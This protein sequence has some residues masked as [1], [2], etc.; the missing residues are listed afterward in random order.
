MNRLWSSIP[1]VALAVACS[2]SMAQHSHSDGHGHSHTQP[3]QAGTTGK[4]SESSPRIHNPNTPPSPEELQANMAKSVILFRESTADAG[5]ILD[6]ES[7]PLSFEFKNTGSEPLEIRYVKPSC[8]CTATEMD[9]TVFAPGETGTIKVEFDPKGKQGAVRRAIT[10]YT[11]S[12]S[13]P[14]HTIYVAAEVQQ[15][16][17]REPSVVA[18]SMLEKGQVATETMKIYGR[19]D[20]FKVTRATSK[21]PDV[22]EIEVSDPVDAEYRGETLRMSEVTVK[23]KEGASP[24]NYRSEISVRTNDPRKPIFSVPIVARIIGDLEPSPVRMTMGR[25][26]V[27]DEFEREIIIRSRAGNAF[28]VTA[29][30]SNTFVFDA[31]YEFEPVD[32]EKRDEWIVRAKGTVNEAAPRFNAQLYVATD[33]EDEDMVTV[34]MYGQLLAN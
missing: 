23:V 13:K 29:V 9:Q 30:N 3:R 20:D 2:S 34:Q 12:E 10:V 18:F 32:P 17:A 21:N 5:K 6:A 22:F 14:V 25:L 19:T 28:N 33:V 26:S 11:N 15:I 16:V 24:D 8:G 7:V 1:C 31:E 27:G 4:I